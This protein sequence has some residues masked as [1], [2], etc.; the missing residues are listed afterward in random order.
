MNVNDNKYVPPKLILNI[1]G[2]NLG[3]GTRSPS[4]KFKIPTMEEVLNKKRERILNKM[5]KD[6]KTV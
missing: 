3:I 5:L 4:V 6:E 2:G 1:K